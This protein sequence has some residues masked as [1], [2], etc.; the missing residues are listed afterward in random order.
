MSELTDLEIDISEAI[1]YI[2]SIYTRVHKKR[3]LIRMSKEDNIVKYYMFE[4]WCN[5]ET[6]DN[7]A[8]PEMHTFVRLVHKAVN[9]YEEAAPYLVMD[10]IPKIPKSY[11]SSPEL[12]WMSGYFTSIYDRYV[13]DDGIEMELIEKDEFKR[14]IETDTEL[15]D[16]IQSCQNLNTELDKLLDIVEGDKDE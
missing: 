7:M 13:A 2:K 5:I 3:P 8:S 15:M 6:K 14:N 10:L 9:K 11:E 4:C 16:V 1:E 12:C